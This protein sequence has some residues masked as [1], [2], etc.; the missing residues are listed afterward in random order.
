MQGVNP[1]LL[2][3]AD[4]CALLESY[5]EKVNDL[6]DKTEQ[7]ERQLLVDEERSRQVEQ[8]IDAWGR[9]HQQLAKRFHLDEF[10]KLL[11][12]LDEEKSV[13]ESLKENESGVDVEERK[14]QH[15]LHEL[16]EKEN[17]VHELNKVVDDQEEEL[18]R[19]ECSLRHIQYKRNEKT[20]EKLR[21]A[22]SLIEDEI[23]AQ[24]HRA[25]QEESDLLED[26]DEAINELLKPFA[27]IF[28]KDRLV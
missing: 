20:K 13:H 17:V 1:L 23:Q 22:I 14:Q 15:Y 8:G 12:K 28:V 19:V 16:N 7:V 9:Q 6:R 21:I 25:K 24:E 4:L 3:D 26:E 5:R 27:G 18:K 11:T 10:L 2:S